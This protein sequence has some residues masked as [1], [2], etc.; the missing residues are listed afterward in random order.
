MRALELSKSAKDRLAELRAL[1][2]DAKSG[3]KGAR[4]ALRKAV[5]ESPHE[6]VAEASDLARQGQWALI[7]TTAAGKPLKEEALLA[8]LD[9]MRSEIAGFHPQPLEVFAGGEDRRGVDAHRGPRIAQHSPTNRCAQQPA[10]GS[11][12]PQV[13][14]WM[15]GTGPPPALEHDKDLGTAAPTSEWDT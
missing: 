6:V 14:P 9:L 13:L 10:G 8:R 2:E 7:K 5:R 12:V 4:R 15:A 1:S 11:Q 3:D